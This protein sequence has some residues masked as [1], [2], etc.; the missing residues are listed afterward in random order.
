M[1]CSPPPPTDNFVALTTMI[2]AS[3]GAVAANLKQ[4]PNQPVVFKVGVRLDHLDLQG[5]SQQSDRHGCNYML[6]KPTGWISASA[7]SFI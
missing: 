2:A 6:P 3:T 7:I 1:L 4:I 5:L